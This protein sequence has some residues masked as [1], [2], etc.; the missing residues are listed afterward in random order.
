MKAGLY[1]RSASE[2]ENGLSLAE[3]LRDMSNYCKERGWSIAQQYLA[4]GC[5]A[6]S[7]TR[8]VLQQ[9]L[10]DAKAGDFEVLM[11]QRLDRL[12]R[13]FEDEIHFLLVLQKAGVGFVSV[14]EHMDTTTPSGRAILEWL[15]NYPLVGAALGR[16]VR[17]TMRKRLATRPQ[18]AQRE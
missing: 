13:N 15:T 1:A 5:S 17:R 9:A 14:L 8:P 2:Q 10:A 12:F 16:Q 6:H 11:V 3:Q 4:P 18:A 7:P